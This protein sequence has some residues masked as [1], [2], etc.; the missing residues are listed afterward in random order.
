MPEHL[1]TTHLETNCAR[2]VTPAFDRD[3]ALLHS[4]TYEEADTGFADVAARD[5]GCAMAH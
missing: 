3:V 2:A 1:G 5:P 4:F